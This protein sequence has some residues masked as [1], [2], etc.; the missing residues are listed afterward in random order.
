MNPI[1]YDPIGEFS[2]DYDVIH[3]KIYHVESAILDFKMITDETLQY[4]QNP[5][6]HKKKT[7]DKLEKI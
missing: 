2:D 4:R 6:L 5:F 1:P 7:K 3:L